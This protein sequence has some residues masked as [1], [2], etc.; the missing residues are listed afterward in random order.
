MYSNNSFIGFITALGLF[1]A[2]P[3]APILMLLLGPGS[4]LPVFYGKSILMMS[5]E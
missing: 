2:Y 5:A 3:I 4:V 1:R